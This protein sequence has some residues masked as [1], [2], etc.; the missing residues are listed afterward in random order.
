MMTLDNRHTLALPYWARPGLALFAK[1]ADDEGE[2]GNDD[3][4]DDDEEEEDGDDDLA[5]LSEEELRDELAKARRSL[6]VASGSSKI[7]RDKIKRLNAELAEARRPKAKKADDDEIDPEAIKAAAKAE[8]RA[9]SDARIRRT[10]ARA[11][12]KAAGIPADQVGKL[13]GMLDLDSL[14]VDDDGEIDGLDEAIEELKTSWP[15]LFTAPRRKR[16]SVAG[17]R[18]DGDGSKRK[19]T[20]SERQAAAALGKAS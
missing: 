3:D 1:K 19:L 15:Q 20:A 6:S 11:E 13:V 17:T 16:A 9:E 5:D 10:A 4:L 12:L 7:K 8:A 2:G 18:E 14:D